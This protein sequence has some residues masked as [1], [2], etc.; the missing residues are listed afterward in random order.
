MVFTNDRVHL[1]VRSPAELSRPTIIRV[2]QG[3]T[4]TALQRAGIVER[5]DRRL[6]DGWAWCSVL[7]SPAAVTAV[8]RWLAGRRAVQLGG[9]WRW[10]L[11]EWGVGIG[12]WGVGFPR[13]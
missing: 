2:L 9:D 5:W 4:R 10:Q 1:L 6:W 7:T 12:E 13:E 3:V 8:R 11:D